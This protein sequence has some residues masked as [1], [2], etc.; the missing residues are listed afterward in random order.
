GAGAV[1][2][3]LMKQYAAQGHL[4][5]YLTMAFGDLPAY[6]ERGQRIVIHRLECGRKNQD[7]SYLLEMLRFA[8]RSRGFLRDRAQREHFDLVHAHAIIPDGMIGSWLLDTPLFLTAHGSD[9]PG[10]NPE[11][12]GL[13]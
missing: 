4:V 5:H 10:Y 9:V 1:A 3:E 11:R 8:L 7:S 12:L 6:E 13:S 2:S